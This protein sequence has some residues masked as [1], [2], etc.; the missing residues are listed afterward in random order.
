MRRALIIASLLALSL[1]ALATP[2]GAES[3]APRGPNDEFRWFGAG[4]GHGLGLSQ[5]GTYGLA[6]DGWGPARILT[7]YYSGTRVVREASPPQ[8]L[9]VGLV[10]GRDSVRLEAEAGPVEIRLGGASGNAVATI[11]AGQT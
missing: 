11:P 3:A 4:W 6:G 1:G 9:R 5:W 2:S 7:H 8:D 10:Q